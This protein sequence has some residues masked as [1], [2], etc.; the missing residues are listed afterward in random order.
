MNNEHGEK[1]KLK[2][3]WD[4]L[5]GEAKDSVGDLVNDEKMQAE[6]KWD[7]TK[8]EAKKQYGE[9]K[10]KVSDAMNKE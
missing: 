9:A 10:H 7:K 2:G 4:K 3:T 6:G 1:E 8:G 5:K